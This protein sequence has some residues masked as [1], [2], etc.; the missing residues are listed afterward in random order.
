MK[1]IK[2]ITSCCFIFLLLFG[3]LCTSAQKY[4]FLSDAE[5]LQLLEPPQ[6]KVDIVFDT[7]TYNEIDDQ[8]AL[9]YALL[10]KEK[11]NVKAVYAAPFLNN[12]STSAGEGMELSYNEI[13][14][15]LK[16]MNLSYEGFA[17]K[18]S[19][20]FLADGETPQ[21]SEAAKHLVTLA[22]N[23]DKDNPLYVLSV[24]AITNVASAILMDPGITERIVVVWLGGNGPHWPHNYEFNFKQD[25]HASRLIFDSGVPFVQITC[26]PVT[27]HLHTTVP[28]MEKNLAGKGELAEYL[29]KIFKD[30]RKDHFGWSKVL[31]DIS[32]IA[33]VVN[34]E[35]IPTYIQ[36]API[37]TDNYTY[38]SDPRRHLMRS[39]YFIHRDPIF[40]DLF[41]KINHK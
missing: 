28:E 22:A 5:R 23:Y 26:T 37:I 20:H 6:G 1:N 15:I 10:S 13:L 31:W 36:H 38:S 16:M 35:W 2:I 39:A 24:G 30:Y 40:R 32:T 18:G 7:D 9:V 17:F 11:M 25:L 34:N 8:F 4:K 27:T 12:R 19:R 14:R 41:T 3:S 21:E 29:L 33:W